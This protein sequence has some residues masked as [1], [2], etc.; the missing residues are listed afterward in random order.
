MKEKKTAWRAVDDDVITPPTLP[1]D[2]PGFNVALPKQRIRSFYI[3][4]VPFVAK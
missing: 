2:K 1:Q 3:E 4:Y